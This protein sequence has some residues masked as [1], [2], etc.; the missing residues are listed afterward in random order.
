MD[1]WL[2]KYALQSTASGSVTVFCLVNQ[3]IQ[4]KAFYALSMGHIQYKDATHRL[5]K[6]RGR[7]PISVAFLTRLAVDQELQ[8]RGLG[9]A[10]LKDAVIR[11][12]LAA[13]QI[14]CAAIAVHAISDEVI[15][16][17]SQFGFELSPGE[18]RLMMVR[19]KD[20]KKAMG[21]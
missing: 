8:G 6:G 9:T 12:V 7:Y 3:S 5:A 18:P 4:V 1:N 2:R 14:G 20:I 19:L 16:F 13:S 11:T 17:Y 10:L 15:N 21:I